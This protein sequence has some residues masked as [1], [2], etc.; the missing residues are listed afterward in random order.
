MPDLTNPN[1]LAGELDVSASIVRRWLRETVDRG[2]ESGPWLIDDDLA[3]RVRAHFAATAAARAERPAVCAVDGCDRTAVG[4]G[5]CRMHYTRW[6]RHGSTD[7][8]DG[9]DRQRAKTHCPRGHEYTPENMIVYPSDG[10]RRC[11]ACRL[12]ATPATSPR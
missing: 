9:A 1:E 4:R 11:R 10:R 2:G 8:L 5:L 6:D 7:K 12:G 3:D